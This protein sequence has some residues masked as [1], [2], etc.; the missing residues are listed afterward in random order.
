MSSSTFR[1]II[2]ALICHSV[3]RS[4][5]SRRRHRGR[6]VDACLPACPPPPPPREAPSDFVARRSG[7]HPAFSGRA[8]GDPPDDGSAPLSLS[9][10]LSSVSRVS[11]DSCCA[12]ILF[13]INVN[14]EA[15]VEESRSFSLFSSAREKVCFG[16]GIPALELNLV[17][18][19]KK[20]LLTTYISFARIPF[21]WNLGVLGNFVRGRI[22]R[23]VC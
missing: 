22:E 19:R 10:S 14:N 3:R 9:L 15:R 4:R 21:V 11:L 23:V 5:I 17:W 8:A 1:V 7:G 20:C 6:L 12:S 16:G 18:L 2:A 13:D